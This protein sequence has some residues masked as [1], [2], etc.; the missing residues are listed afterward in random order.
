MKKKIVFVGSFKETTGD[1]GKGG[2]MF[3]SR[4]LINSALQNDFE[5]LLIDTTAQS[6][7]APPVHKRIGS[8]LRRFGQLF[9]FLLFS[10]PH[11]VLL[12][13]SAGLS[14]LEKGLMAILS[15]PFVGKVIFAPRSGL[16]KDNIARSGFFR[17]FAKLVLRASDTV[18]CQGQSW[19][20]FYASLGNFPDHKFRVVHNWIDTTAYE[21]NRPSYQNPS[22]VARRLLY[23]GW[24]EEYKGILDLIEAVALAKDRI[25]GLQMDV[26]GSGKLAQKAQDLAQSLGVSHLIQFR[27]WADETIKLAA[28]READMYVLPSHTEGF[29]NALLEAMA[30]AIPS[31]A[32]DV[33]GVS[34]LIINNETGLLVAPKNP[35]QLSAAI[36][37]LYQN[38]A[39]RE[40]LSR[41]ARTVVRE[42][43]SLAAMETKMRAIFN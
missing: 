2:Q 20:R 33:G 29:P 37:E 25:P 39:L 40:R 13:S 23:I 32:T 21:K 35:T 38:E 8:V 41:N 16:I 42:N 28:L 27:G 26:Y 43:H 3:A 7:P 36:V 14:F 5:F 22:P 6:I 11:Y 30:S 12:F 9:K 24:L 15:K 4:T 34:D 10:R 31:I 17:R 1:G 18:I 19:K